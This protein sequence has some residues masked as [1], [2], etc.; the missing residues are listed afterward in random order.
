MSRLMC[1]RPVS[2]FGGDGQKPEMVNWLNRKIPEP[3]V[4]SSGHSYCRKA[5]VVL[6]TS[7]VYLQ[8]SQEA[9]PECKHSQNHWRSLGATARDLLPSLPDA[10]GHVDGEG[11]ERRPSLP[12]GGPRESETP[13][14]R[15]VP[16][17]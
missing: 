8:C 4:A 1:C 10:G 14:C 2:L 13:W 7:A 16:C 3:L 11:Q 9:M 15:G 5:G 6:G 12:G 17:Q